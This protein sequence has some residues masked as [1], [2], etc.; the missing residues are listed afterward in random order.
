MSS[1]IS[2][3]GTLRKATLQ[4]VDAIRYVID[5]NL[6]RLLPRH[7]EDVIELLDSFYVID[8]GGTIVGCCCLEVYSPKIAEVR[9]LAVMSNKRGHDYGSQLVKQCIADAQ[10]LNIRQ[11]LV[12]TSSPEFFERLNFGLCLNEK[13]AMF[14]SGVTPESYHSPHLSS[15]IFQQT[16]Q[17]NPNTQPRDQHDSLPAVPT[18]PANPSV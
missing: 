17:T 13:Y 14:W 12:V 15:A 2:A 6:D 7:R 5:S 1:E 10:R 16:A 11:I 18:V 3:P 9:S 4:D 8:E